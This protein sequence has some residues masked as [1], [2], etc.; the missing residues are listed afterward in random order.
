MDV[1]KILKI[2]KEKRIKEFLDLVGLSEVKN[3]KVGK[4]LKGMR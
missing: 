2:E 4:F 3:R 1:F